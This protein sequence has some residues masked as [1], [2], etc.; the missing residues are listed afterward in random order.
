M[1]YVV[2]A[3]A[4]AAGLYRLDPRATSPTPELVVSA[5]SLVGVAFSPL[6]GMALASNDTIWMLDVTLTGGRA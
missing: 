1:L 6:G 5:P 2:E 4:G 3:L